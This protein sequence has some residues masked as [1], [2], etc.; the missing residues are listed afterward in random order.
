MNHCQGGDGADRV[1][2]QSAMEGWVERG[3][4]PTSV[5][6]SKIVNGSVVRTHPLCPYPEEA[7]YKSSGSPSDA[8]SFECKAR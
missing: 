6:A 3:Q 4:R 1:D 7:V 5:I 2:M 8:G